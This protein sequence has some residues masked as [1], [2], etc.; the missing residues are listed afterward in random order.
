MVKAL[1]IFLE[2][3]NWRHIYF[4]VRQY[5]SATLHHKRES[6]VTKGETKL[7]TNSILW[8]KHTASDM[9]EKLLIDYLWDDVNNW[10]FEVNFLDSRPT[11]WSYKG[12]V[13]G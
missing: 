11:N 2:G 1:E 3:D 12:P 6:F 9:V 5:K 10:S 7:P 13:I 8:E 4:W